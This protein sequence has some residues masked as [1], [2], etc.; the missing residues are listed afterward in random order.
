M[1][2]ATGALAAALMPSPAAPT[3]AATAPVTSAPTAPAAPGPGVFQRLGRGARSLY[4]AELARGQV[5]LD[6]LSDAGNFYRGAGEQV[7]E[8]FTGRPAAVAGA[9]MPPPAQPPGV[10]VLAPTTAAPA[11][12]AAAPTAVNAANASAGPPS[13][14][15]GALNTFTGANGSV[16]EV[17][18]NGTIT[19]RGTNQDRVAVAGTGASTATAPAPGPFGAVPAA[20]T[21]ASAA[22]PR[23]AYQAD[24][25]GA[26]AQ[27]QATFQRANQITPQTFGAPD[28]MELERRLQHRLGGRMTRTERAGEIAAFQQKVAAITGSSGAVQKDAMDAVAANVENQAQLTQANA[29]NQAAFQRQQLAGDQRQAEVVAQA[30][31]P[32]QFT[33]ARGGVFV[34]RGDQAT[35]V[36]GPDGKPITSAV[37]T[38]GQITP[39]V[40]FKAREEAMAALN[41]PLTAGQLTPEQRKAEVDAIN[42]RYAPYLGQQAQ[43]QGAAGV[44]PGVQQVGTSPDGKPVYQDASGKKFIGE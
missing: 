31:A 38:P 25:A 29:N 23:T 42:A 44:P 26:R 7:V 36:T 1:T 28:I 27:N 16:R 41:D 8:G 14:Q 2:P 12:A 21:P 18:P 6:A 3:A 19:G 5:A 39:E 30:N 24:V 22:A 4:E 32:Q 33:D 37:Q 9:A 11:P 10:P 43:P 20:F 40:A 17:L 13:A 15:P 34:R 35:P